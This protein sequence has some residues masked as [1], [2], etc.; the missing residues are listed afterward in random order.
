MNKSLPKDS[1]EEVYRLLRLYAERKSDGYKEM[2]MGHPVLTDEAKRYLQ[3]LGYMEYEEW[4]RER[5]TAQGFDYWD[6]LNTWAPWYWFKRNAFAATVAF[7]T[8]AT[9]ISSIVFNA[10]D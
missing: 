10:L 4:D 1:G 8:V 5:L 3:D 2:E 9:A 7:A 6:K